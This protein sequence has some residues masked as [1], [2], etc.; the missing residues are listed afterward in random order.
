MTTMQMT[1]NTVPRRIRQVQFVVRR[2]GAIR[3]EP[4][5]Q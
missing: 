2:S 5:V 1:T 3:P 4:Q